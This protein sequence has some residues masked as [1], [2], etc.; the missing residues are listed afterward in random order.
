MK[1]I[2]IVIDPLRHHCLIYGLD[3]IGL[4]LEQ[5]DAIGAYEQRRQGEAPWL[6]A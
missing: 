2:E 6:F 1:T 4:T 5:V 3:D